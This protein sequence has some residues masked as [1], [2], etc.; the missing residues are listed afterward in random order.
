MLPSA[1][2]VRE[3]FVE[4]VIPFAEN[5]VL[6][7]DCSTIDVGTTAELA[8]L[9]DAPRSLLHRCAGVRRVRN[10]GRRVS[11]TSWSA[12]I[13]R[14]WSGPRLSSTRWDHGW[15]TSVRASSRSG[16]EG[17]Q[18]HGGRHQHA[19]ACEG[20]ALAEKMGLDQRK[21]LD[22]WMNAGVRSWLLENRCPAPGLL[23]DVPS[24][25]GYKPGFAA[26]MMVKDLDSPSRPPRSK[27]L[28]HPSA[29]S[30]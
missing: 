5:P 20:F 8:R 29:R 24:S 27:V 9:A 21:V 28:P 18:Q 13:R 6:F 10:G 3:V 22:L 7:I 15:C 11:S 16:C 2:V 17:L 12:E 30:R 1:Q 25:N 19:G 14:Q 23:P 26:T 4:R